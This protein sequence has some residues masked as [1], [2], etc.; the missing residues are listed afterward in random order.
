[1]PP[2]KIIR[3]AVF[4]TSMTRP[5]NSNQIQ[6]RNLTTGSG[7]RPSDFISRKILDFLPYFHQNVV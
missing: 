6:M 5:V 2:L 7:F 4:V 1:M 3:V